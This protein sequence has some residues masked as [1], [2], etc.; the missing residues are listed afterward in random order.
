[1]SVV[2]SSSPPELALTRDATP[3]AEPAVY[4][5]A[6]TRKVDNCH[7]HPRP[8]ARS[9][10]AIYREL[11]AVSVIVFTAG[12]TAIMLALTCMASKL[13]QGKEA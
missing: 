5:V 11:A 4:I 3:E 1:M 8:V 6:P 2:D 9:L 13:D 10:R 7:L 12:M